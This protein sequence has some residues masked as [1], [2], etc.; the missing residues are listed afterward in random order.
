MDQPQSEAGPAPK[1]AKLEP[2]AAH[3]AKAAKPKHTCSICLED[4][5]A[6]FHCPSRECTTFTCLDDFR[7]AI[8]EYGVRCATCREPIPE[9]AWYNLFPSS[10]VNGFIRP[11]AAEE[12]YARYEVERPTLQAA[13][14]AEKRAREFRMAA[15]EFTEEAAGLRKEMHALKRKLA[16]VDGA[17][18]QLIGQARTEEFNSSRLMNPG[19]GGGA[20]PAPRPPTVAA[21]ARPLRCLTVGCQAYMVPDEA[22]EGVLAC[23]ICEGRFCFGCREVAHG[24]TACDPDRVASVKLIQ[25]STVPC[26]KC[27]TR[28]EKAYG[29]NQMYCTVADCQTFFDYVTGKELLNGPRHNPEYFEA[30]ARGVVLRPRPVGETDGGCPV[31]GAGGRGLPAAYRLTEAMGMTGVRTAT[32]QESAVL[33]F[34]RGMGHIEGHLAA[35]EDLDN[36]EVRAHR[37]NMVNFILGARYGD[38]GGTLVPYGKE[39]YVRDLKKTWKLRNRKMEE[40]E[41]LRTAVTLAGD[42]LRTFIAQPGPVHAFYAQ[43]VYFAEITNKEILR[44]AEAYGNKP[45]GLF[46]VDEG[47]KHHLDYVNHAT[48]GK[49]TVLRW[50][51]ATPPAPP[52][53]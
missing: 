45:S 13:A 6:G 41:V 5:A 2:Q 19:A 17:H 22:A 7:K 51:G 4:R 21:P 8:P 38:A 28:V 10:F 23:S 36:Q 49:F 25:R 40:T 32:R 44:I 9:T 31:N 12:V 47:C 48:M 1:R 37:K 11:K 34:V 15:K 30:L 27:D 39:A 14:V 50:G 46:I 42:V 43:L 35:P 52:M 20:G 18:A 16:E 53:G 26:P 3:A 29:C 24:A 33:C